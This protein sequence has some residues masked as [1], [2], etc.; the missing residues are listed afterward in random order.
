MSARNTPPA[1]KRDVRRL[2]LGGQH[3]RLLPCGSA[4]D[5]GQPVL[6]LDRHLDPA[7]GQVALDERLDPSPFGR[8]VL[9]DGQGVQSVADKLQGGRLARTAGADEAVQAIGQVELGAIE[10]AADDRNTTDPM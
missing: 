2:P 5:V 7:A 8:L 9:A 4:D 1:L 3:D 6:G 10:K